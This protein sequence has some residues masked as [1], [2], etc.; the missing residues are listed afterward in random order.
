MLITFSCKAHASVTMFG[1][2]GLQFIKMLGHS[3]TIPGAID[4][5]EVSQALS[6]LRAA[7]AAEQSKQ[8]EQENTDDDNEEVVEAP[9]NIGSRAFPLV[10]L[11]KAAIKDECEVM[12]EDGSGKRL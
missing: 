5:S 9:V 8:V 12:W 1:E 7:I 11:L 2:V 6:N 4:A 10:E 3:G